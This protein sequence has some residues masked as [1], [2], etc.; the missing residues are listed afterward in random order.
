MDK[1]KTGLRYNT[2]PP[3][4][5]GNFMPPKSDLVYPSLDDFVDVNGVLPNAVVNIARPKAV[6][7]AVKGNK[8]NVVK[9]SACADPKSVM[10]SKSSLMLDSQKPSVGRM[11]S[12]GMLLE[13]SL[14]IKWMSNEGKI[15][16]ADD[17]V[18]MADYEQLETIY[19]CLRTNPII[20][21][22][23][24]VCIVSYHEKSPQEVIQALKIKT[25]DRTLFLQ[26]GSSTTVH[27]SEQSAFL[28]GMSEETGLMLFN[29][30]GLRT[31]NFHFTEYTKLIKA[32]YGLHQ[33][34]SL[35]V[36]QK[37][38]E[39][40]ISQDKYVNETLNKFGFSD[41]KTSR[42][43]ME[44]QKDLLKDADRIPSA[45]F[46]IGIILQ[47]ELVVPRV[48]VEFLAYVDE[49]LWFLIPQNDQLIAA[50]RLSLLLLIQA[51]VD[52]KKVIITETS[53]RS[54]LQLEDAEVLRLLLGNELR[55]L[56]TCYRSVL[57]KPKILSQRVIDL[58]KTKTSQAAKITELKERVKRSARVVSSKD[59]CLGDQEDASKQGRKINEIDQDAEVTLVDETQRR[60]GDNLIF[61]T[62]VLDNEQDMAEKEVDMVKGCLPILQPGEYDLW[63][64]RMEQ[65][66]QFIDYTLWEIV[67]NGNAPIVTKIV[68]SKETVIPP[69]SVE[70]KA[71]RRAE[72]KARSTLLLKTDLEQTY[73][74]I[75]KLIGQ[76]EMHGEV[77]PQEDINRKFLRSLSQEWTMHTIVWMN[78]PEIEDLFNNLEAYES[79]VKGTS[80][81]TT[82][83]HNVAF[84]SLSSTNS[85]TRAVNTA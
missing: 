83:S 69:T 62:S 23:L 10:I 36:K 81:S 77:I 82:N 65:Y 5:N 60:Y 35:Q 9:A 75:Q 4:Y 66:L 39:I 34:P 1:C 8:G 52:K 50:M 24:S 63:K 17:L 78:K 25:R 32:L 18:Q 59:E 43:P 76:L 12:K 67:E 45:K 48:Q 56:W 33:A 19:T 29:Q 28:Y 27:V 42:T 6:L 74:R 41:V 70:E 51:I 44:T 73:E 49:R 14:R 57:H 85:T 53:V 15:D 64:K 11:K 2:V 71:Q 68:D 55:R 16:D 26:D 80:S 72:L 40:F 20:L 84:L 31:L 58:E 54:D 22:E 21:S 79:E 46:E 13:E 61:D 30:P 38:V 47:Q 7:S 3:P 37:E